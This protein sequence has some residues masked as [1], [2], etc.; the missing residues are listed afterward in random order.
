MQIVTSLYYYARVYDQM[1]EAYHW[2]YFSLS[3][4]YAGEDKIS[5]L[6]YWAFVDGRYYSDWGY[7]TIR[8]LDW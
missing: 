5:N 2:D 6:L 3:G 8:S 1:E 7:V 4:D